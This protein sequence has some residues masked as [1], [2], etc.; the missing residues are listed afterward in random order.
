MKNIKFL[1][2][3][4]HNFQDRFYFHRSSN[5]SGCIS[6]NLILRFLQKIN[7]SGILNIVM[8][9]LLLKY[10]RDPVSNLLCVWD[11]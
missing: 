10:D 11:E 2:I 9:I 7:E 4:L 8:R 3:F 6:R 5:F 1:Y